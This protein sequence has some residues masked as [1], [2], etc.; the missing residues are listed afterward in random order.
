MVG[1]N[2][3]EWRRP[4]NRTNAHRFCPMKQKPKTLHTKTAAQV[5]A[6]FIRKGVSF[7]GWAR[8]HGFG[9]SLVYEVVSGRKRCLRGQS[10]QI[11]V[12]L[13]MKDGEIVQ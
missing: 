2:S 10:H 12:L 8:E 13:G 9:R 4:M 11:A 5:R 1:P 3:S 7:A 6:E